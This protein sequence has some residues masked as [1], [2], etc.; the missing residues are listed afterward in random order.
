MCVYCRYDIRNHFD[1]KV[2]FG[3]K[4]NLPYHMTV[5]EEEME[6]LLNEERYASLGN[7]IAENELGTCSACIVYMLHVLL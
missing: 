7:D 6:S 5:Q 1:D 2:Q 3:I 4:P